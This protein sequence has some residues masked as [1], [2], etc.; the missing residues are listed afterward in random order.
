MKQ[1]YQVNNTCNRAQY[2]HFRDYHLLTTRVGY[3]CAFT[4]EHVPALLLVLSVIISHSFFFFK[5]TSIRFMIFAWWT[6]IG[7]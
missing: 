5:E 4:N 1:D 3:D 2:K 7:N 6:V